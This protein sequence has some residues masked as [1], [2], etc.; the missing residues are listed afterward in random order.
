[1]EQYILLALGILMYLFVRQLTGLKIFPLLHEILQALTSGT[2]KTTTSYREKT[3]NGFKRMSLDEKR[4][5]VKYRYYC[6]INEILAAFGLS[7]R[8]INVEGF[9]VTIAAISLVVSV[10]FALLLSSFWY[11]LLLPIIMLP[12]FI[13]FIFLG[14]RMRVRKRKIELLDSMDIICSIMND[15]FLNA[16]KVSLGQFPESVRGYFKKFVNNVELLNMSVPQAI[17]ELNSEVGSLY[18][19]FC[20]SVI[21]YEAN[22]AR[23]MEA[24]FNFYISENG[25]T[26]ARDREIKRLSDAANMDYFASL[27]V[28]VLFGVLTTNMLGNGSGGLWVTPFGKAILICL[29]VGALVIFTYIQYLL[30]KP[31]IYTEK[32]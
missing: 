7:E 3:A 16:V 9:T 14:S 21:T 8:G 19:E 11:A 10:V 32:K 30:S 24:L 27:G 17:N 29:V 13:A 6:F 20:D 15:G 22:R 26:Q 4:K 5:S 25:K 12:A 23:G 31:F 28:I 1:M 18:D 2:V